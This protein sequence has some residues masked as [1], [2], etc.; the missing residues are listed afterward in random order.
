MIIIERTLKVADVTT[1]IVRRAFSD[2]NVVGVQK[3]LDETAGN[4][5]EYKYIKL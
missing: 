2:D 3:F 1:D 5:Y 4:H